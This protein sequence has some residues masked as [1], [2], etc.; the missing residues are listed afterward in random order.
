MHELHIYIHVYEL[1]K[2]T[3]PSKDDRPRSEAKLQLRKATLSLGPTENIVDN[4][5]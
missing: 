1:E 3:Y 2:I 4:R 5:N